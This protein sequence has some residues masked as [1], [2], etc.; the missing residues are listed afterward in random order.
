MNSNTF[1][2]RFFIFILSNKLASQDNLQLPRFAQ[3]PAGAEVLN[4]FGTEFGQTW[5][6]VR[7]YNRAVEVARGNGSLLPF[8]MALWSDVFVLGMRLFQL[9]FEWWRINSRQTNP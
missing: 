1:K 2:I 8:Q 5:D 4:A 3:T 9:S 6:L 7:A